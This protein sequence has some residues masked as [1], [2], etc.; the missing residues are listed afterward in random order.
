MAADCRARYLS[1]SISTAVALFVRVLWGER[2]N[3]FTS[4]PGAA[5][6][7]EPASQNHSVTCVILYE[8]SLVAYS[9]SAISSVWLVLDQW[10]ALK[11]QESGAN[12]SSS[13]MFL[14]PLHHH[15]CN[16]HSF[17]PV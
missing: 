17:E 14:H 13:C 15:D 2:R 1:T 4:S 9:Y 7:I 5:L 10:T 12:T 6:G 16:G 11:R 3:L 8:N